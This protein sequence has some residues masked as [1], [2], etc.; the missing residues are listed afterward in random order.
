L[1]KSITFQIGYKKIS[2]QLDIVSFF[3]R[4][5]VNTQPFPQLGLTSFAVKKISQHD[6]KKVNA[7]P[8]LPLKISA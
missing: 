2:A 4:C 7:F 6:L 3:V 8:Y 1:K 5:Y